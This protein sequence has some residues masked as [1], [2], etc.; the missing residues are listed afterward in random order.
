MNNTTILTEGLDYLDMENQIIPKI[1]V[2]EYE[3]KMGKNS[4]IVTLTFTVKA[5]SVGNDLVNW[6]ERGYDWILDA[7]VST[8]E[9]EIGKYLV[10]A[11]LNRRST[12]PDRIVELLGDLKSLTGLSIKDW[13]IYID[14]ETYD[15]DPEILSQVI[16]L[17]PTKYK[18]EKEKEKELNE[19]RDIANIS[20]KPI[21]DQDEQIRS[22]KNIA[23]L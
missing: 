1:T 13:E 8:G 15:P 10:F 14:N 18:I 11:E 6:L 12:V 22:M 23:G 3:A 9:V 17:N 21:Y 4:D 7:S 2:D 19:M 16:V 20:P 5:E